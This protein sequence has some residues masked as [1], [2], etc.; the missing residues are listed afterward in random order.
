[1][2]RL[3]DLVEAIA[4]KPFR[5]LSPKESEQ[6]LAIRND[7]EVRNNMYTDHEI[8]LAEHDRW[9][10]RTIGRDDVDMSA[11]VFEGR[12]AGAVGLTAIAPAH[13][14]AE[15][16]FYLAREVHGKGL[17]S[18]LEFKFL[19]W[20]FAERRLHKLNCEVLSFNTAVIALHKKFGFREEGVRRDHICRD[21]EWIDTVLLGMT[22]T[23]WSDQSAILRQRLFK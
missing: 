13:G 21:D 2:G 5:D 3:V 1:M 20:A 14:R 23:E 22:E 10:E 9:M 6:V 4:F 12:I 17:G 7:P 8:G 18:A 16:A 19:N 11:V 15:W